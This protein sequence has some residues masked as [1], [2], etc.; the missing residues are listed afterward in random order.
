[1]GVFQWGSRYRSRRR[2]AFDQPLAP[3]NPWSIAVQ[4]CQARIKLKA[5]RIYI[6]LML[7]LKLRAT[8]SCLTLCEPMDCSTPGFTVHGILQAGRL[9]WV[10]CPF[11]RGSSRPGNRTQVSCIAGR[12]FT[13]WATRE[14]RNI[15]LIYSLL[16]TCKIQKSSEK[17]TKTM[18]NPSIQKH[19]Q[20]LIVGVFP[21]QSFSVTYT[22]IFLLLNHM[23]YGIHLQSYSFTLLKS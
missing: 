15:S 13:S 14:A 1:M 18:H 17:T 9:E 11:S 20:M 19:R 2:A 7:T 10:A 3:A 22:H 21:P 23:V 12:F 6:L 5:V 8:Q 16:K 4:V